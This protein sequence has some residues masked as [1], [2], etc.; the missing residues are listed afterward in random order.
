MEILNFKVTIKC[1]DCWNKVQENCLY[2]H[3]TGEIETT[4]DMESVMFQLAGQLRK[5]AYIHDHGGEELD[6]QA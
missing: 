3:G 6:R 1:P 5:F 2:C 4:M